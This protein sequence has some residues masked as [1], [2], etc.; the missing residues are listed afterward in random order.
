MTYF[1]TKDQSN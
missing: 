1:S